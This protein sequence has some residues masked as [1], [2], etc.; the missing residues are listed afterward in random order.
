MTFWIILAAVVIVILL[1][2]FLLTRAFRNP[3]RVHDKTPKQ[4]GIDHCKEVFIPT[5]NNKKLYG[6]LI[7]GDPAMPWLIMVHGW[8]RNVGKMMPYVRNLHPK[9]YNIFVFDSRNH[10]KSDPD[11]YSS[12]IKF[13]EDIIASID[14]LE[15]NGK[16]NHGLGL[17]G[18]SIGG[19]ASVFA[20]SQDDRVDAVVS[21]GAFANPQD[22]MRDQFTNKHIP[23][24]PFIWLLFKYIELKIGRSFEEI[25]PENN[26]ANSGAKFLIVHGEKD[27]VVPVEQGKRLLKAA[28]PGQAELLI[29]KGKGHSNCHFEKG[30]WQKLDR[31]F[32]ESIQA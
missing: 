3:V 30:F 16:L 28:R 20:A 10:G 21:V 22:V 31:F 12:L 19:A 13:A 14:F 15:K 4:K 17:I 29:F 8:G 18:L 25:A 5:K 32:K 24:F 23:Y 2:P 9:G 27:D 7:E 26:I 1:T 11:G 6:W